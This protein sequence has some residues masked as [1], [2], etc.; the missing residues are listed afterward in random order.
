MRGPLCSTM[1]RISSMV[2]QTIAAPIRN[3]PIRNQ[4]IVEH[5]VLV[6][7][8]MQLFAQL[9]GPRGDLLRYA[10]A[11]GVVDRL[12]L[13]LQSSSSSSSDC[14]KRLLPNFSITTAPVSIRMA[15]VISRMRSSDMVFTSIAS[16]R[17]NA[18]IAI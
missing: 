3:S 16:R 18:V 12:S 9:G 2:A 14:K 17:V 1:T 7:V 8:A 6:G 13:M 5:I 15:R 11:G 10:H 4:W